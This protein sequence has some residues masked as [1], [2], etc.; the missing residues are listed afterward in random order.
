MLFRSVLEVRSG[1]KL[2]GANLENADLVQTDFGRADVTGAR[3]AKANLE[4]A[5]FRGATG[6]ARTQGLEQARNRDRALFDA[7]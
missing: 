3:F 4:G 5:N 7:N 6:V 1:A 2:T